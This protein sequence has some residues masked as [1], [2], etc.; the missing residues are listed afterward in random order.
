MAT[1]FKTT[2]FICLIKSSNCSDFNKNLGLTLSAALDIT[3]FW[4]TK[5]NKCSSVTQHQEIR[6]KNKNKKNQQAAKT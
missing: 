4:K 3:M 1:I 2:V 6:E 5:R